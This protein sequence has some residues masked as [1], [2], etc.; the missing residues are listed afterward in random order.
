MENSSF[1]IT[2]KDLA[3][4]NTKSGLMSLLNDRTLNP[5]RAVRFVLYEKRIEKLQEELLKMQ[6]WVVTNKKKVVIIFEGRDAAGKGGAIRRITEHLPPRERRV[7]ALPKPDEIES[8]QWYFQRYIQQL[9]REGEIVFFDRSWY[10]RAIVEPVNG[11]CTEKEYE[12]FMDQVNE[13]EKMMLQSNIIL[14]KL[15]FSITKKEQ[16]RRFR[17]INSS[18]T[19][20]WKFSAVDAQALLL[21]DDYTKY[22][23]EMFAKTQEFVPWKIIKANRKTNAR[24][25]AMEYILDQIPYEVKDA[26]TIRHFNIYA[27]D[28]KP[29]PDGDD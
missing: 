3:L 13:V 8:G 24:I 7:V 25:A 20:K 6:Q 17:D 21:W 27:E 10:N 26:E 15:Y 4:L 11:F 22:K 23:E 14:L 2:E 18:P 1:A 12:I 28:K 29:F 19:K 9:P 16:E 5:K